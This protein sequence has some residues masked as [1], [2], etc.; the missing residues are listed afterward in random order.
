ML[1][2]CFCKILVFYTTLFNI[3]DDDDEDRSSLDEIKT[4]VIK[5]NP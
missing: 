1:K 4:F 5:Q 3:D 2:S